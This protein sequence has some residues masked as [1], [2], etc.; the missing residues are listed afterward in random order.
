MS[1]I[2]ESVWEKLRLEGLR[3][4]TLWARRAPFDSGERLLAA[5]DASERRHWLI[6]IEPQEEE[7]SDLKS[8]GLTIQTRE[9]EGTGHPLGRYIDILCID[10]IGHEAFD[11]IGKELAS[12]ISSGNETPAECVS[13]V[14]AKWRRFWDH[15]PID[16]L[17]KEG[18]IGLFAELWFLAWWLIPKR[19]LSS[20][21]CWRGPFRS[22]HDFEWD[23]R[24][25]E[26]KAALSVGVGIHTIHGLEQLAPPENGDLLLFSLQL[27]EEQGATNTLPSIV[28]ACR[29][30][31]TQDFDELDRFE[32]ALSQIGYSDVYRDEYEILRLRIVGEHLYEV[33]DDFPRLTNAQFARG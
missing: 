14:I 8:R 27:R 13:R 20:V 7:I 11:L 15:R 23:V 4:S 6:H 33:R 32:A 16:I 31:L 12:R 30:L 25:V 17:S 28:A 24:S 29:D 21:A 26:V 3:G 22:R 5:L 9:L 1:Q 19:G 10:P 2:S 18:Q